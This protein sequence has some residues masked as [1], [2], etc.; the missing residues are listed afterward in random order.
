MQKILFIALLFN[1][2]CARNEK[3][4]LTNNQGL[5]FVA[6]KDTL[7]QFHNAFHVNKSYLKSSDNTF[8]GSSVYLDCYDS[9]MK[10][11]RTCLYIKLV[12]ENS[13]NIFSANRCTSNYFNNEDK[14]FYK[15]PIEEIKVDW[16]SIEVCHNDLPLRKVVIIKSL[17][18]NYNA[19]RHPLTIDEEMYFILKRNINPIVLETTTD[20]LVY[21]NIYNNGKNIKEI[22]GNWFPQILT[23]LASK[24]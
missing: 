12:G 5:Y 14:K 22:S 15:I 17:H 21:L 23:S 6:H 18:G 2:S 13:F 20:N 4:V 16:D 11:Y 19:P 8:C 3:L 7:Y 1:L 9:N 10:G 24:L